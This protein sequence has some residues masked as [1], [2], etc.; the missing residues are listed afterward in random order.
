MENGGAARDERAGETTLV[1]DTV[2]LPSRR[3][4]SGPRLPQRALALAATVVLALVLLA[5]ALG[6]DGF[7]ALTDPARPGAGAPR[8]AAGSA[9]SATPS[10]EPDPA[11]HPDRSAGAARSPG[12]GHPS[13]SEDRSGGTPAG[14]GAGSGSGAGTL[15]P[16]DAGEPVTRMQRMLYSIGMYHGHRFGSYDEDTTAAVRAFQQWST[17]A[18]AVAADPPGRYGPA[19]RTALERVAP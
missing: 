1:L 16:G 3:R 11:A 10:P 6:S 4:P 17:V 18:A 7:R 2:R 15:G 19:T 8:A 5:V 14:Q 13:P 12:P 9:G